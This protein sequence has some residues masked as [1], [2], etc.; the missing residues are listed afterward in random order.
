MKTRAVVKIQIEVSLHDTWGED[1]K[2]EQ[3]FNQA[4]NAAISRVSKLLL[5]DTNIRIVGDA[6]VDTIIVSSD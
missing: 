1:C 2:I 4:N 6:R 3:D 5:Q